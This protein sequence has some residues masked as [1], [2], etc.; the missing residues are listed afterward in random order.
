MGA[1][2]GWRARVSLGVAVDARSSL[3][4]GVVQS[5]S[6]GGS[7]SLDQLPSVGSSL[8]QP[9]HG[10]VASFSAVVGSS[11]LAPHIHCDSVVVVLTLTRHYN[12]VRG[13]RTG[14]NN[15]RAENYLRRK[16]NKNRR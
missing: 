3:R 16:T 11:Y 9:C 12:A 1:D 6:S 13:G 2:D 14:S 15:S 8:L 5:M 10:S 7:V 4:A